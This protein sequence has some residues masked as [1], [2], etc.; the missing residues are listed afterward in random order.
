[1]KDVEV[2]MAREN[3]K[4]VF[5]PKGFFVIFLNDGEIV[6]EHYENVKKEGKLEVETGDLDVV[7]KGVDAK[8]ICDT[9]VEM[10]L[11][12]RLD[13]ATYLGRELEKA[14]I[15]LRN[16]TEYTQCEDIYFS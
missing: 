13:H 2:V 16:N 14:E 8:S 11:V 12:S 10:G 3:K 6:V 9:I 5:D 7:I 15:A 4:M 1:M